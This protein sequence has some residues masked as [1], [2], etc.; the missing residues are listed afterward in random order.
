MFLGNEI[1]THRVIVMLTSMCK[2]LQSVPL[3]INS[4]LI[5]LMVCCLL[6][7]IWVLVS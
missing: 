5:K 1:V 3:I 7:Y 6:I 4:E 2:Y